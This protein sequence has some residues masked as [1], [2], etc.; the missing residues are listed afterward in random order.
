MYYNSTL[1]SKLQKQ[2][3]EVFCKKRC[4]KAPPATLLKKR[5][6]HRCFPVNFA[7]FLRTPFSQNTSGRLLLK[8]YRCIPTFTRTWKIQL[9]LDPLIF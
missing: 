4:T 5:L 2:P 8:L 9:R 7:K 3:P 6:R 1:M